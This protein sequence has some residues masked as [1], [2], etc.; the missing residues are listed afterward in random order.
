MAKA[1]PGDEL[2]RADLEHPMACIKSVAGSGTG[3]RA[4]AKFLFD[5]HC[6]H[7]NWNVN[8]ELVRARL[9]PPLAWLWTGYGSDRLF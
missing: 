1:K 9:R 8:G 6:E 2:C 5:S 7:E 3:W 4:K